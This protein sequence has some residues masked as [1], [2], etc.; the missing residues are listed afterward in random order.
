MPARDIEHARCSHLEVVEDQG[1][2]L[3]RRRQKEVRAI[4]VAGIIA[5]IPGRVEFAA[6]AGGAAVR[7]GATAVGCRSAWYLVFRLEGV[8]VNR[9]W[10]ADFEC[11][12]VQKKKLP[13]IR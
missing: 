12:V 11:A 6:F 5:G 10:R 1:N 13:W 9:F 2:L 7:E 8:S 3:V 4:R